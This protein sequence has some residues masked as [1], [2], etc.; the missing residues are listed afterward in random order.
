VL[1]LIAEPA[2]ANKFETIGGGLAGSSSI[3][4]DWLTG[5][6]MIAGGITL[7]LGFLCIVTPHRNA[8]FLNST[9]WKQSAIVLFSLTAALFVLALVV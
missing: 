1:G 3:K 4:R 6:F 5:F 2:L 7:L 8:A 9:N